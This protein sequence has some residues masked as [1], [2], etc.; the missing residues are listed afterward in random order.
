MSLLPPEW[1]ASLE[2]IQEVRCIN[3][4]NASPQIAQI[5]AQTLDLAKNWQPTGFYTPSEMEGMINQITQASATARFALT[6][7]SYST[8]DAGTMINQA[9]AYLD[10]NDDRAQVYRDGVSRAKSTGTAVINAPGFKDW[11]LKSLVNISQAYVTV[12][13]LDC[14]TTWLD[15]VG[16]V[17]AAIVSGAKRI[18]GV[19]AQAGQT[20][21][22]VTEA[23]FSTKMKW[24][25][26]A[27][28]IIVGG[29]FAY[30]H[31]RRFYLDEVQ[32]R[33]PAMPRLPRYEEAVDQ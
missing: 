3:E 25:V 19:V 18:G 24:A 31:G 27:L 17:A 2:R 33:L 20:V 22:Q 6:T 11:I 4:A 30:K 8:S 16:N 26:V 21:L 15:T 12:Y 5:D 14:R 1:I 32:P 29:F 28:V 10:R 9:K 23:L 13:A 7:A